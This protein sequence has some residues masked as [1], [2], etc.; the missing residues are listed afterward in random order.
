M[1]VGSSLQKKQFLSIFCDVGLRA[2]SYL[3]LL[4]IQLVLIK[5]IQGRMS[6]LYYPYYYPR[7]FLTHLVTQLSSLLKVHSDDQGSRL[8]WLLPG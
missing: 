4:I 5:F 3:N 8:S 6:Y 2:L 1:R 7:Y